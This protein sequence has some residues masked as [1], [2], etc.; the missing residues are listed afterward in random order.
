MKP[1]AD[2]TRQKMNT[3]GIDE[4]LFQ[5]ACDCASGRQKGQQGIGTLQEKSVHSI[6][7]YYY[8]P[9]CRYHEIPIGSY[10][11]DICRDGEI[12]EIQSKDF[13]VM[14][15]KL[16]AFLKEYEVTIVYP[17]PLIKY[18]IWIDPDT[19]QMTR[20]KSNKKGHLYDIVPEL[21]SIREFL[22]H[23]KLH[24]LI[25]F[26]EMEE[27]KLLDGLGKDHKIKASRTDRLPVHLLGEVMLVSYPDL[28]GF[29][30]DSL[31]E[32]FTSEELGKC[33]GCRK[34]TAGLL[35]TLLHRF[36]LIK[37]TGK[38]GRYYLY[39]RNHSIPGKTGC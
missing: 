11:A 2:F 10:V 20:R 16:T 17:V 27:Y 18:I 14:K 23:P 6:L 30:P 28:T 22:G 9:D 1:A 5:N 15:S 21:Y 37:R 35:L 31:P 3:D 24:F 29:L 26:M 33:S 13:Y 38:K 19:G 34:E 7:K 12:I 39:S 36:D 32:E 4:L 8:A 25:C